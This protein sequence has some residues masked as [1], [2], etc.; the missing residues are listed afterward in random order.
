MKVVC[1]H[2]ARKMLIIHYAQGDAFLIQAHTFTAN[3]VFTQ[4]DAL[5][6]GM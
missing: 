1:Q 5:P 3:V 2:S 4:Q 6:T